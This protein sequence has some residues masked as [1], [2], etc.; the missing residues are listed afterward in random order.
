MATGGAAEENNPVPVIKEE[1]EDDNIAD[2][3]DPNNPPQQPPQVGPQLPPVMPPAPVT[4]Q[5]LTAIPQYDG[6]RGEPFLNWLALVEY[7]KTTYQ[8]DHKGILNVIRAKGGNKVHEWLRSKALQDVTYDCYE[9]A[10]GEAEA[11]PIKE[12]I[13][14]RFGPRY[15][16]SSAVTAVSGLNQ[17]ADEACAD[18]LDRVVLAVDKMHYNL[19]AVQRAEAG[20]KNVHKATVLS[21]FGAGL[22]ESISK[23][24]LSDRELPDTIDGMLNACEAAEV[25]QAKKPTSAHLSA[26]AV[27]PY[28]TAAVDG[29]FNDYEDDEES[30]AE[31]ASRDVST[32][33]QDFSEL[34]AAVSGALDM[35]KVR[36]YNCQRFGHFARSCSAPRRGR[37]HGRIQRG[38]V[39]FKRVMTRMDGRRRPFGA[40]RATMAI[41]PDDDQDDEDG[42]NQQAFSAFEEEAGNE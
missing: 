3:Q 42:T 12:D 40:G 25:E 17:R 11:R 16:P 34:C 29:Q 30:L 14:K 9:V 39:P 32:L 13:H 36:C 5:Q 41:N 19:T 15:T 31:S 20:Y 26:L 37:G 1:D 2:Q 28:C 22:R 18:F 4:A 6:T 8:W 7:S 23:I 35:S 10:H 38:G 24:V 27:Q 33:S 21:M